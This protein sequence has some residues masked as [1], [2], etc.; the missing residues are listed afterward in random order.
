MGFIILVSLVAIVVGLFVGG[1]LLVWVSKLFKIENPSYKKSLIILIV[2]G[3]ASFI[4]GIIFGIINL[5][6][7]SNILVSVATF[8]VF[9]YFYKKYYVST[10]KKSLGIYVVFGIIGIVISLIVVI[11]TRLYIVSPFVASGETMSPTYNNGDYLL[12]NKFSKD[13]SRGDIVVFRYEAQPG[14]F[15]IKR[16]IGLPGEKVEIQNGKV[17]INGQVLNESY[18]SGETAGNTS[19]TVGQDQYFV[20]GD[21]RSKIFDSRSFGPISKSSIEGKVFYKVS[22]LI[23]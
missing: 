17:F 3:I 12:I 20:L 11:P 23:K 15:F 8:F 22:G 10:W 19:V 6:F 13:F 2:S 21:N 7:L 18:Y 9:H 16:I 4:A 5:G 1:G 14:T